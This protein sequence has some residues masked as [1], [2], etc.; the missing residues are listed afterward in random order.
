MFLLTLVSKSLNSFL[1]PVSNEL[2]FFL[3][4]SVLLSSTCQSP[5]RLCSF[6]KGVWRLPPLSNICFADLLKGLPKPRSLLDRAF[7]GATN[8]RQSCYY[9]RMSCSS[10]RRMCRAA[11]VSEILA[12]SCTFLRL[13]FLVERPP[14]L[15]QGIK[16]VSLKVSEAW[17]VF[18]L[19]QTSVR[20]RCKLSSSFLQD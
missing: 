13:H 8:M 14:L 19:G 18:I 12:L 2:S 11:V 9:G 5:S 6:T 10:R 16:E 1:I 15:Y 7:K 17:R 20:P 3:I 4:F